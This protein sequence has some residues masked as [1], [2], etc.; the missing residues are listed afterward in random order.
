MPHNRLTVTGYLAIAAYLGTFLPMPVNGFALHLLQPDVEAYAEPHPFALMTEHVVSYIGQSDLDTMT[1]DKALRQSDRD[2]FVEAMKK[3]LNDHINR[4]H[5][6]V[7]LASAVPK[8][9]V[10]LPMVWAMQH[11]HN[12]IGTITKWKARL[13][14]GGHRLLEFVDYWSTYLP[15]LSWSTVRLVI[16]MALSNDWHRQSIDC[17]LG[18]FSS[19]N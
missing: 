10:P 1:L 19:A 14:A 5:W 4:K 6:K 3:E 12:P 2:Q 18:L 11:K 9:K 7:I 15:V 13:C 17:F 16:V 8:H